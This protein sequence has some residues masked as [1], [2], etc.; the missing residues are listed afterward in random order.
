MRLA[1]EAR[2]LEWDGLGGG[3]RA[4]DGKFGTR[5]L[6]LRLCVTDSCGGGDAGARRVPSRG[7]DGKLGECRWSAGAAE[8]AV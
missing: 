3:L 6:T 5:G 4:E 1:D 7:R 2:G 8:A